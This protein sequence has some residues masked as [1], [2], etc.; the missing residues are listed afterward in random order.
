[1]AIH[2]N[3]HFYL[4]FNVLLVV[5]NFFIEH[6]LGRYVR[7]RYLEKISAV[8][9]DPVRSALNYLLQRIRIQKRR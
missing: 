3:P 2:K 1:M 8:E 9:P 5:R 4:G 6:T 7:Y